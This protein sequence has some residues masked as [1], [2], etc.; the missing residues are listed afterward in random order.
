[1]LTRVG[2][3][4]HVKTASRIVSYRIVRVVGDLPVTTDRVVQ[5]TSRHLAAETG[6]R[7]SHQLPLRASAISVYKFMFITHT[8]DDTCMYA[9][10]QNEHTTGNKQA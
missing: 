1:M 4:A 8:T 9:N 10:V 7:Q 5:S 6:R 2:F 3:R